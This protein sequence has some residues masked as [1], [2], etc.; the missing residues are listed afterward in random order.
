M[1]NEFTKA[2]GQRA[3]YQAVG[4]A[5]GLGLSLG[6]VVLAGLWHHKKIKGWMKKN[7]AEESPSSK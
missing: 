4:T 2:L 1:E 6:A 7:E 5:I 3:R